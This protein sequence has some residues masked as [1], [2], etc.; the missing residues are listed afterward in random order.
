MDKL[1]ELRS[2]DALEGTKEL[3][4]NSQKGLKKVCL[5]IY[6]FYA[7]SKKHVHTFVNKAVCKAASLSQDI[8][9]L[10][11]VFE[12]ERFPSNQA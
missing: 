6:L 8:T 2:L 5:F 3:V 11:D 4:H 1:L 7:A 9:N 12:L 10:K